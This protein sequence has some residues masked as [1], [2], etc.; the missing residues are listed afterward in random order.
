MRRSR[1]SD[2][3]DIAFVTSLVNCVCVIINA[4]C[5]LDSGTVMNLE[6]LWPGAPGRPARRGRPQSNSDPMLGPASHQRPVYAY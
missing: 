4:F 1:R 2:Q 5:I 6:C 3:L